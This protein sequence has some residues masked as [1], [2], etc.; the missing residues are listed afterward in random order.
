MSNVNYGVCQ[1]V[2]IGSYAVKHG[3]PALSTDR[4]CCRLACVCNSTVRKNLVK[5]RCV[6]ILE[7][8]ATAVYTDEGASVSGASVSGAFVSGAFVSVAGASVSGAF[9]SVAGASVSGAFVS[10]TGASVSGA[11]VSAG[12]LLQDANII[13]DIMSARVKAIILFMICLQ[14]E[15]L[16]GVFHL[17]ALVII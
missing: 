1:S 15:F 5:V 16:N 3:A 14:K 13:T 8:C 9:V 6:C 10:T 2:K 4:G 12:V 11:F 17:F 7:E